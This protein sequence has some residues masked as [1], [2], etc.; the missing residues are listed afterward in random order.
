MRVASL[1]IGS[2]SVL[3]LQLLMEFLGLT[4]L[5]QVESNPDKME[6]GGVKMESTLESTQESE[7]TRENEVESKS[8]AILQCEMD[9]EKEPDEQS[10]AK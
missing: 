8:E 1:T 9:N 6:S 5:F 10:I 2:T 7:S 3:P 4:K